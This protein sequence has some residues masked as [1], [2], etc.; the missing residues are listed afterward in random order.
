MELAAVFLTAMYFL[1]TIIAFIRGHA[2]KWGIFIFNI[3][4]GITGVL[5]IVAIIWAT[6]NKGSSNVHNIVVNN[7][8]Q[9]GK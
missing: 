4:F 2:S 5:W 8:Q 7:N 3:F 1:P 9:V 6:S